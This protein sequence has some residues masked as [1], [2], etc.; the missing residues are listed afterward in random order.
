MESI[1]IIPAYNEEKTIGHVLAVLKNTSLINKIIVVSDGSTDNTV[2]VAK[3]YEV[4]VI[5]LCE[6]RGKGG[7][8]KAGLDNNKADVVL[9]LDADFSYFFKKEMAKP[10]LLGYCRYFSP[11]VC[12]GAFAFGYDYVW[13]AGNRGTSN[14]FL[15]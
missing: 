10:G 2:Q 15:T 7:A 11:P 12:A 4:E 5:E 14:V 1:A 6:N 9:F 3:S 8:L 13:V